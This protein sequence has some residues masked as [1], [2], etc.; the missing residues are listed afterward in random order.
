MKVDLGPLIAE[1]SDGR[2]Q[3]ETNT[4]TMKQA[5]EGLA[6][7]IEEASCCE[8]ICERLEKIAKGVYF[9]EAVGEEEKSLAANTNLLLAGLNIWK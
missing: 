4:D 9:D 1:L 6:T 8:P 7:A 2:T 5:I 3:S